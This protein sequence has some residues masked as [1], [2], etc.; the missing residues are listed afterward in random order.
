M[1]KKEHYK[2]LLPHFQQPGQAYFVTWSLKDAI[3]KKALYHYSQKLDILKSQ[4]QKFQID[5]ADSTLI[6]KNKPDSYPLVKKTRIGIRDTQSHL[7]KIKNE[8][9]ICYY[10]AGLKY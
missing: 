8:Y 9:N 4:L 10:S 1:Q 3:P 7:S 5:T 2:H 6:S